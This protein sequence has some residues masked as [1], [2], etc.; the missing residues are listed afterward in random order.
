MSYHPSLIQRILLPALAFKA[1]VI[2][3]GYATGRE[4][5]EFFI[6][7]SPLNG[8][9]GLLLTACIWSAVC[10]FT[11]L[12]AYITKSFDYR[13][14]FINLLGPPAVIFEIAYI[15]LLI[16]VLSIFG[17]AAGEIVNTL[18]GLPV[19]SGSLLLAVAI[20]AIVGFGNSFVENLF[21]YSTILL[22]VVFFAFL[23]LTLSKYGT[24]RPLLTVRY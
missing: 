4:L 6:S 20:A 7:S 11:F 18:T 16:L 9:L 10:I 21:K 15:L 17:A 1:V 23:L 5:V 3:G 8:L 14:F 12:F 24:I 22:Y 13:S 19:I 2:G